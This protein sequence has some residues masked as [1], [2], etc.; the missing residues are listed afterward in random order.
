[1]PLATGMWRRIWSLSNIH[2]FL[3]KKKTTVRKLERCFR[4]QQWLEEQQSWQVA[5]CWGI[6]V[7]L[8]TIPQPHIVVHGCSVLSDCS[9]SSADN[10]HSFS[11]ELISWAIIPWFYISSTQRSL[12][13]SS[14]GIWTV[15]YLS[16]PRDLHRC[17]T[18]MDISE[19][20]FPMAPI[21]IWFRFFH[22]IM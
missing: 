12:F 4:N 10:V 3:E 8:K 2:T 22:H 1:M 13:G 18:C 7:F 6:S 19:L 15:W 9:A 14:S 16:I 21:N 20:C 17:Q 11:A 5:M